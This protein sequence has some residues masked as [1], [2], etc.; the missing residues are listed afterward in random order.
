MKAPPADTTA[1]VLGIQFALKAFVD[2]T[3]GSEALC[4]QSRTGLERALARTTN[5]DH[6]IGGR[7]TPHR[8]LFAHGANKIGV[9]FPRWIVDPRHMH[10]AVWMSNKQ[11]LHARANVDQC[12]A[13]ILLQQLPSCARAEMA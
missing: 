13:R 2:V 7:A 1:V 3:H 9:H 11:K 6:R 5:Q 8:Q 12:C 4:A 10:A